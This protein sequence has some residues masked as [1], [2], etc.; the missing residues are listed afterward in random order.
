MFSDIAL[1]SSLCQF[2]TDGVMSIGI[3]V[4][5]F[6][7]KLVEYPEEQN[8]I[9]EEIVDVVGRDRMPTLEDKSKMPYTN[10]FMYEVTRYSDFFPIFPSLQCTS[11][12]QCAFL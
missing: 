2:V 9:Y 3:F 5:N 6:L 4:G 10:A 11:K 7:L 8:K 1:A 12:Y